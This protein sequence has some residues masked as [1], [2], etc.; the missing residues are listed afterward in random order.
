MSAT[1]GDLIVAFAGVTSAVCC[2]ASDLLVLGDLAEKVGQR[3]RVTDVAPGD[4]D[5][6]DLQRFF[7]DAEVD[8]AP[9]PSLGAP[10][11][12]GRAIRL[13]PPP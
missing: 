12:R 2:D 3:R 1:V 13:H 6:A 11:T 5:D 10:R 9:D 4:L 7:V 8:L